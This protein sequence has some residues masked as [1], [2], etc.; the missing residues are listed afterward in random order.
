[1]YCRFCW[2]IVWL[3]IC[4]SWCLRCGVVRLCYAFV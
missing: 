1:M 2:C 4:I 3:H